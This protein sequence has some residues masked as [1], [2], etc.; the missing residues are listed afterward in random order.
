MSSSSFI[1]PTAIIG[2]KVKIG[3]DVKIGPYCVID[4]E[5]D[6]G[7]ETNLMSHVSI[8]GRT[9]IG[10][11]CQIFPF[12][13]IGHWPQDLKYHGEPSTL[14]IGHSTVIR[15][16]VTIQPGTEG[17]I[18]KTEVGNHCL[19]M[20]GSH[21]AHDCIVGDNVILANNATLAGHVIVG[22]HVIIGGLSAIHQFVRIGHH[23]IIGGMSGVEHDVIPYGS[24]KGKRA[25]LSGLNLVGLKRRGVGREEIDKMREAYKNLF[26]KDYTLAERVEHTSEK[27]LNHNRIQEIIDFIRAEST[28]ALCMPKDHESL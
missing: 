4:D 16:Y 14:H 3:H 23:A 5:V 25:S 28:R 26:S 13:S 2:D 8:T 6:L 11:C 17:G 10:P 21:V 24:V 22:D 20:T 1:H 18:M 19:L 7:D 9:K 27:F 12:S 15:E